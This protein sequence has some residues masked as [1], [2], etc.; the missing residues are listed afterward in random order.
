M[1]LP[2]ARGPPVESPNSFSA[3]S[4]TSE[5]VESDIWA[6]SSATNALAVSF[7]NQDGSVV[8][9]TIVYV[10]SSNAFAITGSPALFSAN[11]GTAEVVVSSSSLDFVYLPFGSRAEG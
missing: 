6:L 11:F 8:V 10:P 9:P 1:S 3:A 4:G 2:V 5:H 7:V